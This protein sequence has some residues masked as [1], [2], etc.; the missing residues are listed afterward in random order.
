MRLSEQSWKKGDP[1]PKALACYGVLWQR[2]TAERPLRD[3]MTLRFVDG[4]PVSDITTQ[5]LEWCCEQLARQ[6]K[7]AWLLIWDNASWHISQTMRT[8]IREHNQQVKQTDT[9]VRILPF[10]LPTKSP[11]LNPIEPKWVHGKRPSLKPTACFRP[12]SWLS[13]SVLILGVPLNHN[14]LFPKRLRESA[15]GIQLEKQPWGEVPAFVAKL[16]NVNA[17]QTKHQCKLPAVMQVVGH[18]T[19]DGPLA[20]HRIYFALSEVPIDLCQIGYRPG[21]EGCFDHLPARLQPLER[22]AGDLCQRLLPLQIGLHPSVEL[23]AIPSVELFTCPGSN[24]T[25][26][27]SR[28]GAFIL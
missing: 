14:C 20:C 8:W 11:W 19:P 27:G 2:G 24:L 9:G 16:G 12:S 15:L 22:F 3:Q 4:R 18:D 6:G 1:D 10:R 28:S 21:G 26:E 7:R 23:V 13:G 25:G 17:L 5:F